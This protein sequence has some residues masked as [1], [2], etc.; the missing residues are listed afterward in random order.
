MVETIEE[1]II[2]K[3]TWK[4]EIED[5]ALAVLVTARALRMTGVSYFNNDDVPDGDQPLD[6]T[7]VGAAFKMLA[8]ANIIAP[9]RGTIE[10]KEIWG[11]MRRSSRR[12]CHGHRNQLYE[13]TNTGIAEEW[14]R[15]HGGAPQP[16]QT[17][18]SFA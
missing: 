6:R 1:V 16:A 13:L 5:F 2:E 11:G 3:L 7:T 4:P 10:S 14:L 15:R 17:E 9:W 18:M 12:C 8:L